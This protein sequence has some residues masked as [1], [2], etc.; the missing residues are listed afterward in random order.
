MS[1]STSMSKF[2]ESVRA[3]MMSTKRRIGDENPDLS[4]YDIL[5]LVMAE[6]VPQMPAEVVLARPVVSVEDED[7]C[8]AR[9]WSGWNAEKKKMVGGYGSRCT[10]CK[11]GGGSYCKGCQKKADV[12]T[13]PC[14]FWEEG[15]KLAKGAKVGGKKGLHF[16]DWGDECPV[17]ST[18]GKHIAIVWKNPEVLP[19][20]VA[21]MEEGL[22]YHPIGTKE[23]RDG[24]TAPP[25]IPGKKVAKKSEKKKR[26][27]LAHH[28]WQDQHRSSVKA[29]IMAMYKRTGKFPDTTTDFLA[30]ADLDVDAAVEKFNEVT[31]EEWA[32]RMEENTYKGEKHGADSLGNFVGDLKHSMI[33][34]QIGRLCNIMY[35]KLSQEGK[36]PYEDARKAAAEEAS[37]STDEDEESGSAS[38][39]ATKTKT[40]RKTKSRKKKKVKVVAPP[41]PPESEDESEDED[42]LECSEF[43]MDDGTKV[44][45]D[46]EFNAY[47]VDGDSLGVVNP[48]TKTYL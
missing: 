19:Q 32:I 36:Q 9:V 23:G 41:P 25:R 37:A 43:I 12:T 38:G 11:I 22:T 17:A 33:I 1:T 46:E 24:K 29:A 2:G 40:K 16:G 8:N 31:T 13:E 27:K 34:G 45:V 47:S 26:G 20:I 10:R 14:C 18:D 6:W 7:R 30:D 35:H 3:Q 44:Y 28:Y 4:E 15:D 39:G 42:E 5:K 21:L 48:E